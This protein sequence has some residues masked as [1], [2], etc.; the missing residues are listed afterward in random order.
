M[1]EYAK[2]WQALT[3]LQTNNVIPKDLD[4]MMLQ[5]YEL[6][7]RGNDVVLVDWA[8]SQNQIKVEFPENWG[9]VA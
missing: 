9:K 4:M 2:I 8:N 5:R 7:L 6:Q 1:I 3:T